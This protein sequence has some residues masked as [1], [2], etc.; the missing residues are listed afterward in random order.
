M[1]AEAAPARQAVLVRDVVRHQDL[2]EVAALDQ[3]QDLAHPLAVVRHVEGRVVRIVGRLQPEQVVLQV[4]ARRR[5]LEEHRP[6]GD[7]ALDVAHDRP[8]EIATRLADHLDDLERQPL[9][10]PRVDHQ[11][12]ARL[13]LGV[14]RGAYHLLLALGPR[15]RR[16]DLADEPCTHPGAVDADGKVGD[17]LTRDRVF[18]PRT[19][20]GRMRG[21]HVVAGPHDDVEAGRPRHPRQRER[22]ASQAAIGRI[23][24]RA[25]ARVLEEQ[26]LVARDVLV[27]QAQVVEVRAEVLADPAEVLH[28]HGLVGEAA[29][30]GG[31]RRAEHHLEVDQQVLVRERDAHLVGR[32]GAEHG[33]RV[34]RYPFIL[35]P[36]GSCQA[37]SDGVALTRVPSTSISQRP[38][39]RL[40]ARSP[41]ASG[42]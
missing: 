8:V 9:V 39:S 34:H 12:S 40:S 24:Q 25:A 14:D 21:R 4:D 38:V 16:A 10:A 31:R 11:R 33:L 26:R 20:V 32:N 6:V 29:L 37:R 28:A 3:E 27:E 42:T 23:D 22:V 7:R 13:A 30:A 5:Q 36:V 41:A 15:P 19:H 2:R 17:D 18:G 35:A 1:V